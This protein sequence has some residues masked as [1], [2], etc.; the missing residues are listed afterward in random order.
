MKIYDFDVEE[1]ISKVETNLRNV[2]ILK[3]SIADHT[4]E[5]RKLSQEI[6]VD[7]SVVRD[8]IDSYERDLLIGVYTYAEQ[9][10]KNF[11]Y[12]LLER[13][14]TDNEFINNFIDKKLDIE[15]FSP[16]VKYELLESNIKN[17]LFPEFQ[18]II[19]KDR[20]EISNY[21]E[22]IKERHK[23]A[24]KGTYQLSFE[25]YN[26][27]IYAE[28]YI[29]K[30]LE[31]VVAEGKNYRVQYQN[32]WKEIIKL[33]NKCHGLYKQ[34]KAKKHP[35]LK[36]ELVSKTKLL[37]DKCKTFYNKYSF[38][39]NKSLLLEDVNNQMQRIKAIDLRTTSSFSIVEDFTTAISNSKMFAAK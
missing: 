20:V 14:Q 16:N 22:I 35:I 32:D 2:E 5:Y 34:F 15:K 31:M 29:T 19:R 6:N 11:Y 13:S 36:K 25:Q 27:V 33:S 18:F 9:L 30:E 1:E 17:E 8:C 3:N 12:E 39:I 24:H 23:Y 28:R 26:D 10:V 4:I 21:D 38:Y 37:R 7:F